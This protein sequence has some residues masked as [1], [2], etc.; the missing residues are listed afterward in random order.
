L[1]DAGISLIEEAVRR[2]GQVTYFLPYL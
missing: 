1:V 2:I